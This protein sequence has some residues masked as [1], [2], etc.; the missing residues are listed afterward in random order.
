M[1]ENNGLDYIVRGLQLLFA[2]IVIGT[3][4]YGTHREPTLQA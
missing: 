3:D 2:P 1:A 4:A